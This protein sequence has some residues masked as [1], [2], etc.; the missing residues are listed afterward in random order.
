MDIAGKAADLGRD[1]GMGLTEAEVESWP[2]EQALTL[3]PRLQ[4]LTLEIVLRAVFGPKA[5]LRP[6]LVFEGL[7]IMGAL[8]FRA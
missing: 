5:E 2:R 1:F 7:R 6:L 4:G 3:H 8:I